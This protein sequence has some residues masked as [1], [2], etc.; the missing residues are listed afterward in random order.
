MPP[1]VPLQQAPQ[2]PLVFVLMPFDKTFRNVYRRGIK[3]ACEAADA[4][5]VRVDEQ[6]FDHSIHEQ[7]YNQIKSADVV[8]ADLSER[9]ANVFYETGYAHGKD[10]RVILLVR[11]QADIPFDVIHYPHIVYGKEITR[12]KSELEGKVRWALDQAY[13]KYG[14]TIKLIHAATGV[15]LHSHAI[16]YSH[17]RTS[18]QQQV[19]GFSRINADNE[20]LIKGPHDRTE[21]LMDTIVKHG[22]VIRLEHKPTRRN[23]HSHDGL[24][25]PV[26]N[27]QEVTCFG[28]SGF[29]DANDNW[30]LEADRDR[31][32]CGR[33]VRLVH[34]ATGYALHS[35]DLNW[36]AEFTAGQQEVT[37]YWVRDDNDWWLA[38]K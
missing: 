30:V 35:H 1:Q 25:S 10:K 15:R 13:V 38:E 14:A 9:N 26:S 37:C 32:L 4:A 12:L 23:L 19:T 24:P 36:S 18:G 27:Q 3:P 22:D 2:K 7:I 33:R 8:V 29:G 31:W 5:C 20:W 21:P 17:P 16:N 34:V 28:G 11:E 6:M